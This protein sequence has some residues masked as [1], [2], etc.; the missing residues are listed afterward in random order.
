[1]GQEKL[2]EKISIFFVSASKTYTSPFEISKQSSIL[3]ARRLDI[4]LSTT[5]LSITNSKSCFLF[6]SRSGNSSSS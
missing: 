5:N 6:L 2:A 4:F 3:S 1:M